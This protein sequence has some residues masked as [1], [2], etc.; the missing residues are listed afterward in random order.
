MQDTVITSEPTQEE[1]RR[2]NETAI[3]SRVIRLEQRLGRELCLADLLSHFSYKEIDAVWNDL[4]WL[5]P[6]LG[7]EESAT[8]DAELVVA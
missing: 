1:F 3:L 7:N 8:V 5:Y 6:N 4:L 2:Q